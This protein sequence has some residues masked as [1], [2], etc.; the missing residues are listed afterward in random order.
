MIWRIRMSI[1]STCCAARHLV[2]VENC[3]NWRM[4]AGRGR[5]IGRRKDMK[6]AAA[7]MM[8]FGNKLRRCDVLG[9]S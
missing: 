8:Y 6:G 4:V 2:L 3:M 5:P 7:T 1:P 9:R